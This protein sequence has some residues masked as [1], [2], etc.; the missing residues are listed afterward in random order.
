MDIGSV[1]KKTYQYE[2]SIKIQKMAVKN[3]FALNTP[4]SFI[5]SLYN[6]QAEVHYAMEEYD[7]AKFYFHK[8]LEYWGDDDIRRFTSGINIRLAQI[9][10]AE[11]NYN[12]SIIDLNSCLDFF[13][14]TQ[15]DTLEIIFVLKEFLV[16]LKQLNKIDE[17]ITYVDSIDSYMINY[18][19]GNKSQMRIYWS[20]FKAL[21]NIKNDEANQYKSLAIENMNTYLETFKKVKDKEN[22]KLNSKIVKEIIGYQ[23]AILN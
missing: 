16:P 10:I 21:R 15:K 7:S 19:L 2:E 11:K 13:E 9:K 17:L 23:N 22:I 12:E 6:N 14:N 4:D 20:M 18:Q 1:F 8:A 3:A 5:G